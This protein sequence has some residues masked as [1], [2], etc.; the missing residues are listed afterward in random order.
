MKD[1]L[2]HTP[3][4]LKDIE[5]STCQEKIE[6]QNRIVSVF[7]RYG[8]QPIQTPTFEFYDVFVRERGTVD[9]K[10]IYKFFDK[11]GDILALR[12][13]ITPSIARFTAA[14][15]TEEHFPL[16]FCYVGN[17]FR[18][19]EK[20]QG[21]ST[22]FTQAGVELIDLD[23]V[24]ADA[25][26]IALMIQ[27]LLL[28]GLKDFQIDIGQVDFFKGL[29]E[30]AGLNE[31]DQLRKIIDEKNFIALERLLNEHSMPEHL[32][33]V[34]L[35]LPKL[36]G[37]IDVLD[38]ASALTSNKRALSALQRLKDV[39]T[40]LCDYGVQNYITFDLGMVN[41]LNYYTGIIFRGYT[42]GTGVS[43]VDGGRYNNLLDQFGKSAPS[44]GFAIYVDELMDAMKRQQIDLPKQKIDT[45]LLYNTSS[46][47]TA[48][49]VSDRLRQDG[50]SII[51]GLM[52]KDINENINYGSKY[53]VGGI[54][55]F[56]TTEQV[57]LID[58]KT[59]N[60]QLIDVNELL[61]PYGK[62]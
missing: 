24:D 12:P 1:C 19:N 39:Y 58:L 22:E 2:L 21:K 41:Q 45:L 34:F 42:Y 62:E 18:N 48:L 7:N 56:V 35:D 57:E 46:R 20:Y 49:K 32:K 27:S 60:K 53:S 30:E 47:A 6:L 26:I 4:G 25:E 13:D 16:R 54:M 31:E 50:M 3:D 14:Y 36:Y 5:P 29:V 51:M 44:I 38:R 23:T 28:A 11:D 61:T 40:I 52:D 8:Y 10:Q 59:M 15:Y 37:S 43:I 55:N 17:T 9:T 33:E